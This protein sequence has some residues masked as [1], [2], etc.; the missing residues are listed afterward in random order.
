MEI[1]EREGINEDL[2]QD[3][4]VGELGHGNGD[5][6]M[7]DIPGVVIEE[8]LHM[9]DWLSWLSIFITYIMPKFIVN[10]SAFNETFPCLV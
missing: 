5:V 1:E 10:E 2:G 3:N 4:V 6:E 8:D 9:E 7:R